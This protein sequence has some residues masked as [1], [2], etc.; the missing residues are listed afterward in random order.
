[1]ILKGMA[2]TRNLAQMGQGGV[3]VSLVGLGLNPDSSTLART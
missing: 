1:M 2:S 3:G